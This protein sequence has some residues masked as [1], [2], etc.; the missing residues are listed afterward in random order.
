ML[1]KKSKLLWWIDTVRF[2]VEDEKDDDWEPE[3]KQRSWNDWEP[4]KAHE[5][6]WEPEQ[7]QMRIQ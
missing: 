6:D 7:K 5:D 2:M 4:E 1:A 3:Q